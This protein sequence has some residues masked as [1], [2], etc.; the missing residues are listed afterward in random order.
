MPAGYEQP[1]QDGRIDLG[2]GQRGPE[3]G[4]V[5]QPPAGCQ[6]GAPG[7][8]PRG[9]PGSCRQSGVAGQTGLW[10]AAG[11]WKA[12]LDAARHGRARR[13]LETTDLPLDRIAPLVGLSGVTALVRVFTRWEGITPGVYRAR[14][15][16]SA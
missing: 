5:G 9:E 1:R 3:S 13:L 4:V 14:D 12:L 2:A 7:H 6:L 10:S 15:A 8:Q 16:G 11:A